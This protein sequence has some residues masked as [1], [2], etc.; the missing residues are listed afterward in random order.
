MAEPGTFMSR[1]IASAELAELVP[2]GDWVNVA[3]PR[4]ED[5]LVRA[6]RAIW[7]GRFGGPDAD[8]AVW[9]LG[10]FLPAVP[11]GPLYAGGHR[12]PRRRAALAY[13]M[14]TVWPEDLTSAFGPMRVGELRQRTARRLLISEHLDDE[15]LALLTW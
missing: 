2:D 13:A 5:P 10:A 15:D 12:M 3:A 6:E 9:E 4:G 7:T 11:G 14:T 1:C 8:E